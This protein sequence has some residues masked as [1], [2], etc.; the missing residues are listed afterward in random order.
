MK[1]KELISE[2]LV[3]KLKGCGMLRDDIFTPEK[4][5]TA[6]RLY[7]DI[8]TNGQNISYITKERLDRFEGDVW[9][10][11]LRKKFAIQTKVG[12]VV[13]AINGSDLSYADQRKLRYMLFDSTDFEVVLVSGT[14]I[15]KYYNR[16]N[17][18]ERR[19][20]LGS[21]CM[22]GVPSNFFEIYR[23]YCKMAVVMHKPSQKICARSVI[24]YGCE[25]GKG[26]AEKDLMCKIYSIDDIFYDML[27]SWGIENGYWIFDG[28]YSA[29][30][31]ITGHDSRQSISDYEPY[32]STDMFLPE[33][34]M[35]IPYLDNFEYAVL[36][37]DGSSAISPYYTY[38]FGGS[39]EDKFGNHDTQGNETYRASY[40]EDYCSGCNHPCSECYKETHGGW[41]RDDDDD[42]Y[43]DD[44]DEWDD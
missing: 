8:S 43:G 29:R 37:L 36:S 24:F 32:F 26:M 2:R 22:S 3:A 14:D 16:D 11:E 10:E 28:G 20:D 44:Y 18:M 35:F 31:F 13:Q 33:D 7:L 34:M 42:Y 39:Y 27:K 40:C 38:P 4:M 19:G 17:Y 23:K 6:N 9:N 30:Y 21:S 15:A 5:D 1:I 12:R 41:D 25:S